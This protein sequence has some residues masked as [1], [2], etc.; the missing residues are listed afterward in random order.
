MGAYDLRGKRGEHIAAEIL[1]DFCGNPLPYFDPHALGEKFPTYDLLV[2]LTG[3]HASKPYFLAQVKSTGSG[4]KK[5]TA[6]LE[7]QLKS[8]DVLAMIHCPIPTY[9]IGV[10][11]RSATAYIVSIHGKPR[12]GF[13][14]I[15]TKYP[16]DQGNLK[17][18]YDEVLAYWK[19]LAPNSRNKS[20]AFAL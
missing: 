19:T 14:S 16:L 6:A 9:L 4:G 13:S 11:E 10:D 8:Q 18:L 3:R 7:V 2:E 5:G 1:L 20:S 17:I 15:P 12:R